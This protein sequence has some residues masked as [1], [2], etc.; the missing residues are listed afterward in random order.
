MDPIRETIEVFTWYSN[1]G[2]PQGGPKID[3]P[4]LWLTLPANWGEDFLL[5]DYLAKASNNKVTEEQ[6]ATLGASERAAIGESV[7]S[8][9]TLEPYN[10]DLKYKNAT[11]L[12]RLFDAQGAIELRDGEDYVV[13]VY[14]SITLS[15]PRTQQTKI[16]I[17]TSH[18]RKVYLNGKLV[19][20][21]AL[22]LGGDDYTTFFPITLQPGK[23]VFLI[24]L[25]DEWQN[26]L[27]SF[28]FG[29]EPGTEYQVFNPR[30]GYTLSE[31]TNYIG[32]TFTLDL[33]AE[34]IFDFAGWQFDIAFDPTR[35]E[36]VEVSEGDF[37]KTDNGTTFF[38]KGTIDNATGTITKLS[39]ARLN[40]D[41]V[42]GTGTLLSVTFTAKTP[43]QTQLT[44]ENFQLAAITGEPIPV[45]LPEILITIEGQLTTGDVNRDGQVSILDM[46]L[47]ARQ[48]GNTVSSESAVDINGD[49][50]INV[51]DL[52]LVSQNMGKSSDAAAP[53]FVEI[54]ARELDPAIVRAW[55]AQ[56]ALEDDGSI[57]FQQGLAKLREL[58][59]SLLPK[60][61]ALLANYPN[62]F[63]PE[64]WIPY[65]LAKPADVTLRIYTVDGTLVRTLSLG[66]QAAGIYQSR[67]RAAYWDGKNAVGEPVASGVYFYTLTAGDF[68]ATR[69][70]L[71]LK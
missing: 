14:G 12:T 3:G 30:V 39:S 60:E 10:A 52:I 41:G 63:N 48:F 33:N 25:G 61:T 34:N 65:Q 64:T 26:D 70:M 54:N 58:L 1:P 21:Q 36:A 27:Y 71:I 51:L 29:F 35:L 31:P 23:N 68:T 4:W 69:K 5:T 2:F 42:T 13:V 32:D 17:G 62:P 40:E 46:V 56:A 67:N 16:F 44:L 53:S 11:N 20:D 7:W 49:G 59:S 8:V 19:H 15:S 6:I 43:G 50:V 18:P 24:K 47:V 28:F 57:A 55:I 45:G 9:G 22:G 37:L 38:Q 66:H